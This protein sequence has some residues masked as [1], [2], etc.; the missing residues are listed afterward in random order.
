MKIVLISCASK[1]L[2]EKAKATDIYISPLFKL[3]KKYAKSLNPD[4]IFI[5]S[6]KYELLN[7]EEIIEPYNE[8]LNKMSSKEIEKWAKK[9]LTK[10]RKVSNLKKD[11]FIFLAGEKYRKY[12]IPHLKNYEIPLKGLGIGKQL[13]FLKEKTSKKNLCKEIHPLF[14]DMERLS[15]P[16]DEKKVPLNGIYVLF[17]KGEN[18]H[19]GD[20]IVRVGS[21]TGKDQLKSRIN[22]HFLSENKDRSI[23]RKNIGRALLNRTKDPYLK[24]WEL[25]LTTRDS[26]EKFGDLIDSEKQ[27]EIEKQVTKQLQENFSFVVFSINDSEERLEFESKLISTISH[28]RGCNPSKEWMGFH[29]P[30][31]KIRES[32]LW[33]VNELY[34]EPL[35]GEELKR[36][37]KLI[38]RK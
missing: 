20:R 13:K 3:N 31:Q 35:S 29:S 7:Q 19:D 11:E 17:E 18:A 37:K 5:L 8:T 15:F 2:P 16:F 33:L 34:K 9:V 4:K 6:A 26:K 10:L 25:D 27:D 21:H 1:K 12:L 14:N 32:G 22:Q 28:C 30:K 36:L 38:E 24:V 23:F